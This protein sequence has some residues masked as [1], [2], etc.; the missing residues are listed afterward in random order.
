[1]TAPAPDPGR[2]AG[3]PPW[4]GPW[5]DD[6]HR[7]LR[8]F[9]GETGPADE[10]AADCQSCPVCRGAAWVRRSGPEV[11]ERIG[12]LAT[13]LAA[14]L[15]DLDD[16]LTEDDGG[17]LGPDGDPK[18]GDDLQS[19]DGHTGDD[20]HPAESGGVGTDRDDVNTAGYGS[21]GNGR[22]APS[23]ARRRPP[24]GSARARPPSTV[25]IDVTD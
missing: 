20:V 6:A 18:T 2:F 3:T 8:L 25:R 22:R 24:E 15:R 11:L 21:P 19:D 4:T 1:M 5:A 14:T 17:G 16:D 13:G 12:E 10:H 9:Q 7:I 23:G